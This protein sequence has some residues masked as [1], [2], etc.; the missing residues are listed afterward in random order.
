MAQVSLFLSSMNLSLSLLK[1]KPNITLNSAFKKAT[2]GG[3]FLSFVLLGYY[4]SRVN[5]IRNLI[6]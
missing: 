6:P 2:I 3:Y 4:N 5:H 1:I